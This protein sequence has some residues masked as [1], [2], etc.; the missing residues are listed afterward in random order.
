MPRRIFCPL[1]YAAAFLAIMGLIVVVTLPALSLT[2]GT[3]V[4]GS[5]RKVG[6]GR[7]AT[8]TGWRPTWQ[9]ATNSQ[10]RAR[11]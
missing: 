6:T 5:V 2:R 10:M 4:L 11:S 9:G 8:M 3:I 7:V 1:L